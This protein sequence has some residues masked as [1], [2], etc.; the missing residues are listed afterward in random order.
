MDETT[1]LI[2][3]KELIFENFY[4]YFLKTFDTY[5]EKDLLKHKDLTSFKIESVYKYLNNELSNILMLTL[6][7]ELHLYSKDGKLMGETSR[8]RFL[9]FESLVEKDDFRLYLYDKYKMLEPLIIRKISQTS[10]YVSEIINNFT[11]DKQELGKI[12]NK[13][14]IEI[15]D[16]TLGSGDT[17]NGGKTVAII[18]GNFGKIVY[19]P[20]NLL[21]DVLFSN[22]LSFINNNASLSCNLE[23]LK[24]LNKDDYGWQQY[25]EYKECHDEDGVKRYYYRCGVALSIF[26][27]LGTNDMHYENVIVNEETPYFIDLETLV[28]LNT[29]L[30]NIGG[31]NNTV[32]S[33]AYIPFNTSFDMIDTD[34]SGLCSKSKKSKKIKTNYF[35]NYGTDEMCVKTKYAT[36]TSS[37]N[38]I[39]LNGNNVKIENYTKYFIKGFLDTCN[40]IKNNTSQYKLMLEKCLQ[41][42]LALRQLCRHTYVYA[43]FLNSSMHPN[44]LIN[45]DTYES[46]FNILIKNCKE[47]QEKLRVEHEVQ[48]LLNGDVPCYYSKANSYHLYSNNQIIS[49]NYFTKTI[50][51][52]LYSK[53]DNLTTKEIDLQTNYI[54]MS[55][56]LAYENA[57]KQN[58]IVIKSIYKNVNKEDFIKKTAT[59]M[60]N[61]MFEYNVSKY[62]HMLINKL[63]ENNVT[64]TGLDY[65][66]YEGGGMIWFLLCTGKEYNNENYINNALDLLKTTRKIFELEKQNNTIK[67]SAFSGIGSSIYLYYNIAK[68]L[69]NYDFYNIYKEDIQYLNNINLDKLSL[70]N[71]INNFDFIGGIAGLITLLCRIYLDNNNKDELNNLKNIIDKL[72]TIFYKFFYNNDFNI[73]GMAHGLCGISLT[74]ILIYKVN[75]ENKYLDMAFKF[76]HKENNI[77][78]FENKI[79]ETKWCR[80]ASGMALARVEMLKL[81]KNI[82]VD[83]TIISEGLSLYI[84]KTSKEGIYNMSNSNLC[85]GIYGNIDILNS[86]SKSNISTNYYNDINLVSNNF[87]DEYGEVNLDIK[88]NFQLQTF[89]LG[90]TGVA[91]SM[92][93]LK[94]R[95]LPSLLSLE[96]IKREN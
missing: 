23:T 70:E 38:L 21:A 41:N 5:L 11:K 2:S 17:H 36:L 94:N 20:H 29:N 77:F 62:K 19:K 91:Y 34:V 53:V 72:S 35:E 40:F 68:L 39:L 74:C 32:L 47:E 83:T 12:F 26:Y 10:N 43:K 89:M 57:F 3:N 52:M 92:L 69:N 22:V 42:N 84:D 80:G 90:V 13:E 87:I 85:H 58:N 24:I 81:L 75:K 96:I 86:I 64:I 27:I 55:L 66:L 95:H 50:K 25:I 45:K 59:Q 1:K 93:R 4:K 30:S 6:I 60:V 44:Y 56:F 82:N 63:A 9:H 51:E 31:I 71:D 78:I 79:N 28:S 61:N 88:G 37:S 33:T 49:Y 48:T 15:N 67:L 54:K 16:I 18:N 46:L 65:N 14:F 76:L 7:R 73:V 8:E